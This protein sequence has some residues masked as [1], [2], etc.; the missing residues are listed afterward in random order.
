M[1]ADV[2]AADATED[3]AV[4]LY[5]PTALAA[6]DHL[7]TT[8]Q[9]FGTDVVA[10][11]QIY[12]E[13]KGEPRA[14]EV[15]SSLRTRLRTSELE[16]YPGLLDLPLPPLSPS[17]LEGLTPSDYPV[18][19]FDDLGDDRASRCLEELFTCAPT[20]ECLDFVRLDHRWGYVL[21]HQA[22]W[23]L[24]AEWTGCA[25]EIDVDERRHTFAVN[26]VEAMRV[27]PRPTDLA[28]ERI[29]LIGH[30]GFAD[31]ID[32]AW[33]DAIVDAQEPDGCLPLG[34]GE[35]CHPHPTAVAVWALAHAP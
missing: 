11:V 33:L 12:G 15:A 30:L 28:F 35:P 21:T 13:L 25:T 27:D 31:A 8:D 18:D 9:E 20:M 22:V 19:P 29:A 24:F 10:A 7:S 26:L 1:D 23:L 6:L 17:T 32:P 3:G 4:D 16:R 5:G 14:S 34:G 2:S